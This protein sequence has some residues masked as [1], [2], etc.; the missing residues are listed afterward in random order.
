MITQ[1]TFLVTKIF[2]IWLEAF[3]RAIVDVDNKES[4]F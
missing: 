2:I 3:G 1:A 4:Q